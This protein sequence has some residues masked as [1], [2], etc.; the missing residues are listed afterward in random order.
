MSHFKESLKVPLKWRGTFNF[1]FSFEN[2]LM[3]VC[4][5]AHECVLFGS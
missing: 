1:E 4:A 5:H 3:Y 2:S